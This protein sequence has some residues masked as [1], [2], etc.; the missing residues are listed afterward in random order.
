MFLKK[1][2]IENF[3]C[4]TDNVILNLDPNVNKIETDLEKKYFTK[5]DNEY[6]CNIIGI[7][8]R[9]SSGKSTILEAIL[10]FQYLLSDISASPNSFVDVLFKRKI[11]KNKE[12]FFRF[13]KNLISVYKE[14][15]KINQKIKGVNI[16]TITNIE[17]I[18]GDYKSTLEF[19]SQDNINDKVIIDIEFVKDVFNEDISLRNAE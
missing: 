5:I 4:F 17:K 18:Y 1:L 16:D 13:H 12:Q 2:Q 15:E 9:N 14:C 11:I 8:G 6:R 7:T 3:K 10:E 19:E